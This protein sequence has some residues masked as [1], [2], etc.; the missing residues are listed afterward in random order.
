MSRQAEIDDLVGQAGR[1]RVSDS[2][3]DVG[4]LARLGAADTTLSEGALEWLR[5]FQLP[6]GTWGAPHLRYHHDRAICT[7]S[8]ITALALHGDQTDRPRIEAARP[9]L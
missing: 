7:L 6:D 1:G 4:W 9:G 8:A 2:A 3:Y 5:R